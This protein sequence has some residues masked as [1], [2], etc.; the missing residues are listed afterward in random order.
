M[1]KAL[2]SDANIAHWL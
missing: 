2:K 1:K